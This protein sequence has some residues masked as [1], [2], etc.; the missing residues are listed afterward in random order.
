M[1][2]V[3]C[4][5]EAGER[6]RRGLK[7]DS[8]SSSSSRHS[9]SVTRVSVPV[10]CPKE[11]VHTEVRKEVA[12]IPMGPSPCLLSTAEAVLIV[13]YLSNTWVM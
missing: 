5:G 12:F 1:E 13:I 11:L 7:G 8:S 9:A 6:K 10:V 3:V 2:L 4:E